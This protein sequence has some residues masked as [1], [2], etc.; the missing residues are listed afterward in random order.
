MSLM[1]E[2]LSKTYRSSSRSSR[3]GQVKALDD[4]SFSVST[5]EVVAL[6]GNNGAGKSTLMSIVAGLLSAD[7]GR[8]TVMGECTTANGG[9]PSHHL[10]LAP[11]E[12]ALYPTLTVRR[13]LDYFGS[14]AGLT[15][16]AL[17]T[18]VDEVASKLLMTELLDRKASE[19]SGGQRRRLHTGLAL[20]HGPEVLLLDE[21]TVGVDIDARLGLLEFVRATAREG[22]SVLYSTH[23]M[24]EVEQ[25]ASRAVVIDQGV[26]LADGSVTDLLEQWSPPQAELRFAT[27]EVSIPTALRDLEMSRSTDSG[28]CV[29]VVRLE[30]RSIGIPELLA[31]LDDST[32]DSVVSAEIVRPSFE[33]SYLRIV[34]EA[35]VA[36]GTAP[37]GPDPHVEQAAQNDDEA[38]P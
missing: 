29:V 28:D 31:P 25:I 27:R 30:D 38:A 4:V 19:C 22:A 33:N 3:P 8:A 15:G 1:V 37:V 20:M 5:G 34:R 14:L 10:G 26:V 18:R 7:C 12:E 9:T 23:Q 32:R 2:G 16:Q 35:A 6:V 24:S 21:P 13:N 17:R 36:K 11:Q